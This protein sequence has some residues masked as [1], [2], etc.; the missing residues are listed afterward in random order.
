MPNTKYLE[1]TVFYSLAQNKT[2]SVRE[3]ACLKIVRVK[4]VYSNFLALEVLVLLTPC[5]METIKWKELL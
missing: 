4:L 1:E 2:I 3:Q 5:K